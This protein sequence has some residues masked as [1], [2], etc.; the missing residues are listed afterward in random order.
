MRTC[1]QD[2]FLLHYL[3]KRCSGVISSGL[4]YYHALS[5]NIRTPLVAHCPLVLQCIWRKNIFFVGQCFQ[6]R[7][8]QYYNVLERRLLFSTQLNYV[9]SWKRAVQMWMVQSSVNTLGPEASRGGD[10]CRKVKSQ[11]LLSAVV[12]YKATS[13]SITI[14]LIFW[15]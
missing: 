12:R 1:I 7:T 10:W 4:M 13:E 2:M 3:S 8:Q 9:S 5:P 6:W 14:A 15:R 11:P